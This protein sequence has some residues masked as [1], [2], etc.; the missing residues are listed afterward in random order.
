MLLLDV[1]LERLKS[2]GVVK[3][4]GRQRTDSIYVLAAVRTLNRVLGAFGDRAAV[5]TWVG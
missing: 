2:E 1:L 4:R 5:A 3:A